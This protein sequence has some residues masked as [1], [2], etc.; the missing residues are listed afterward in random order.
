MW[1]IIFWVVVGVLTVWLLCIVWFVV[2]YIR[3]RERKVEIELREREWVKELTIK[4][5]R[6]GID[7]TAG[8]S[9]DTQTNT[10]T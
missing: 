2:A 8:K 10:G 1:K 5:M 7:S 4:S 6:G 3:A 9:S